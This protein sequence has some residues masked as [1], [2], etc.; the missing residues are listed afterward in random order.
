MNDVLQGYFLCYII[1]YC[2][3]VKAIVHYCK[4]F[5]ARHFHWSV[6]HLHQSP[7]TDVMTG[8]SVRFAGPPTR[9]RTLSIFPPCPPPP[10][11]LWLHYTL[12]LANHTN[13]VHSHFH[14]NREGIL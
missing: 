11:R 2:M 4:I 3:V 13:Y 9:S 6:L 5:I 10:H 12:L 14:C 7:G 1:D 8:D